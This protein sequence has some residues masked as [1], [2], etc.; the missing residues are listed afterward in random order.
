VLDNLVGHISHGTPLRA[1]RS[2]HAQNL[3]RR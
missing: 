1:A 3:Q 2:Y